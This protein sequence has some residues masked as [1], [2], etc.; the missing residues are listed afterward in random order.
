MIDELWE[1]Y[2]TLLGNYDGNGNEVYRID[3]PDFIAALT[4]YGEHIKDQAVKVCERLEDVETSPG[5]YRNPNEMDCATAI[6][7]MEIK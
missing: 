6:E 2:A 4:E 1:K 5:C 7:K 3:K